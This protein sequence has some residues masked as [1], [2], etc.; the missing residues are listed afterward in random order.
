M[1]QPSV[2]FVFYICGYLIPFML[3][4]IGCLV[5]SSAYSGGFSRIAIAFASSLRSTC[6]R[7]WQRLSRIRNLDSLESPCLENQL[8]SGCFESNWVIEHARVSR[9]DALLSLF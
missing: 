9:S 1:W 8:N 2:L 5:I 3:Q 6:V 4:I 7:P